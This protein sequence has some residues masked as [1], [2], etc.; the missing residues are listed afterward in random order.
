MEQLVFFLYTRN[1]D[2]YRNDLE[3]INIPGSRRS[4]CLGVGVRTFLQYSLPQGVW[5]CTY[6]SSNILR[7]AQALNLLQ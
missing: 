1:I 6:L 4:R 5:G 7:L 3:A 2:A